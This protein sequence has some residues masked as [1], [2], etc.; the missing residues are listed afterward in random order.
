MFPTWAASANIASSQMSESETATST[1]LAATDA[2]RGT[3]GL[4]GGAPV[5]TNLVPAARHE[6]ASM[7]AANIRELLRPH[8]SP[9]F[10]TC[11]DWPGT[12]AGSSLAP[13]R[14]GKPTLENVASRLPVGAFG[15]EVGWECWT[16]SDHAKAGSARG[17]HRVTGFRVPRLGTALCTARAGI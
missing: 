15:S 12:A 8:T 6:A 9:F 11:P 13:F 17:G 4:A 2:A 5:V 3:P 16:G 10:R 7:L 14:R 1:T